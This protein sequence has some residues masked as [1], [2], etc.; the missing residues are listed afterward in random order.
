[1]ES[2]HLQALDI[3]R[4]MMKEIGQTIRLRRCEL[5][6]TQ[7]NLADLCEVGINTLA[8]I[9]K[10]TGNPSMGAVIKVADALGLKIDISLK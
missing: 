1:M 6:I 5:G 7:Q 2:I 9:E 4:K 8:A 3:K 10:G